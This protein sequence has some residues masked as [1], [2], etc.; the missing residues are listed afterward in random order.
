ML[1]SH[2]FSARRYRRVELLAELQRPWR[3]L[4]PGRRSKFAL[5]RRATERNWERIS[6]PLPLALKQGP[7][8]RSTSRRRISIDASSKTPTI[9]WIISARR[10]RHFR[11]ELWPLRGRLLPAPPTSAFVSPI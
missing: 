3:C 1:H 10:A 11:P 9:C 4:E 7:T 6:R 8:R 2:H 5:K